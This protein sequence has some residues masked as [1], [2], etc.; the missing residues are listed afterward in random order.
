[1]KIYPVLDLLDGVVVRGVAGR[2]DEYRPV[3]SRLVSGADPVTIARAFR[4]KF[5]LTGLY[6]ADLDAI[7]HQRPSLKLYRRLV[8]D[9]FDLLVDAG[10]RSFEQAAAVFAAGASAVIAGL[11]TSAGPDQ[12]RQLCG[13]FGSTRIIFSLDMQSGKPLGNL[14]AWPAANPYEIAAIAMRAGIE[15][16]IVLDLA[17]VGVGQGVSTIALCRRLID[18]NP[19]LEIITGG[20]VRGPDDLA[21]L[22]KTGVAGVL[23]ASALHDGRIDRADIKRWTSH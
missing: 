5:G 22:A 8:D 20:G 17:Q 12:L 23:I 21:M 11:E 7:L 9:G 10:V 2:R 4:D 16:M 14:A 6:V 15:R 18:C 19:S 13:E 3:E 1:M